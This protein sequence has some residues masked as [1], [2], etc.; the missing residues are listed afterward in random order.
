MLLKLSENGQTISVT[1][2]S[3]H[4]EVLLRKGVLKICIKFTGEHRCRSAISILL[5]SNFAMGVLLQIYC[6]LSEHLFLRTSLD[7]CFCTLIRNLLAVVELE[8][9]SSKGVL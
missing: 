1:L 5:K 3:S 6:I 4:P 8:K 2:R 9:Q 7:G